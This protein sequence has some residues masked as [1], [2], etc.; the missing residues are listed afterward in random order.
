M[1]NANKKKNKK[2][3]ILGIILILI[4]ILLVALPFIAE[5]SRNSSS[6]EQ[7]ILSGT[8]EMGDISRTISG[9]GTLTAE[10]EEE[11]SLPEGVE[12]TKYLVSNSQI[13]KEGDPLASVDRRSVLIAMYNVKETIEDIE[14]ELYSAQDDTVSTDL[15]DK[16]GEKSTGEYAVLANKHRKYEE[17]AAKLAKWYMDGY[18]SA[19]FDGM[20]TG[21]DE[22]AA[23]ALL[24]YEAEGCQEYYVNLLTENY[25]SEQASI[26]LLDESSGGNENPEYTIE[27]EYSISGSIVS[28]SDDGIVDIKYD[29]TPSVLPTNPTKEE[30]NTSKKYGKGQGDVA[31]GDTFIFTIVIKKNTETGDVSC[32]STPLAFVSSKKEDNKMSNGMSMGGGVSTTTET[33]EFTLDETTIMSVVPTD[34][35]TI[36]ITIDELDI[37]SI[38]V[39]DDAIVTIDALPGT[40]FDG[41]VTDINKTAS[42]NGGNTK[43]SAE[44]TV[45]RD[46]K[47]LSG[48]NASSLITIDIKQNVLTIPSEA[49]SQEN[50]KAI[51]YLSK[52]K[53]DVLTNPVEITTG[54]SDG[55][56]VEVTSGLT[57]GQTFYYAYYDKV[58]EISGLSQTSGGIASLL[59]GGGGG[60]GRP[61]GGR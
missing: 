8:A 16:T 33:E 5:K 38:N 55:E 18:I 23:K 37:L 60:G 51:V 31:V 43:Y 36:T 59:G 40:S 26:I 7:S 2:N 54:W 56:K 27:D 57:E 42:N 14:E 34:Y 49:I 25:D 45:P 21:I 61:G 1:E 46:E 19:P 11:I 47:M 35:M 41:T 44:V 32:T 9:T 3:I 58:D 24:G 4:V 15:S 48:M 17:V 13:V 20:V 12:V 50:G 29:A 39:G 53:N 52:D 28:I 30:L 6:G 22:A 10:D